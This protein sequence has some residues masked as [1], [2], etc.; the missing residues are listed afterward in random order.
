MKTALLAVLLVVLAPAIAPAQTPGEILARLGSEEMSERAWGA[1]LAGKENLREAVPF[2]VEILRTERPGRD[3]EGRHY[4]ENVLDAL[5]RLE[6]QVPPDALRPWLDAGYGPALILASRDPAAHAAPL[7]QLFAKTGEKL[8]PY[9]IAVGNLLARQ[10]PPGFTI[11]LLERIPLDLFVTVRDPGAFVGRGRSRSLSVRS[12]DGLVRIPEGFPPRVIYQLT[13]DG[14]ADGAALLADGPRPV[15][16][17]REEY[18]SDT[19]FGSSHRPADSP[20]ASLEWLAALLVRPTKDPTLATSRS[21]HVDWAGP[22][23]YRNQVGRAR[24]ALLTSWFAV[25]RECFDRGLVSRAEALAY[26]PKVD[27]DVGDL[28]K[29]K[30]DL[31]PLTPTGVRLRLPAPEEPEAR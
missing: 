30:T 9:S 31:P 13:V 1:Y 14:K 23:D 2:L 24:D 22:D 7:L 17:V 12:G 11:Q 21:V 27:L 4:F 18:A 26:Q 20:E 28:R 3:R 6:A 19:G 25:V 15:F 29:E 8:Y 10:P 5:I 16:Y